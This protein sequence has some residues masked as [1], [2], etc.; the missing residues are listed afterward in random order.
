MFNFFRKYEIFNARLEKQCKIL[1][2]QK[3]RILDLEKIIF[4][5]KI[6]K[7]I[8][9]CEKEFSI[10][11]DYQKDFFSNYFKIT[12]SGYSTVYYGI[13]QKKYLM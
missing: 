8:N 1:K 10:S 13:Q 4:K 6:E 5:D 7:Y 2:K 9:E 11:I 3:E 12:L